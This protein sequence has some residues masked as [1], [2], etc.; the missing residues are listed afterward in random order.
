MLQEQEYVDRLVAEY[1]GRPGSLLT[2]LERVQERASGKYLSA[3]VLEYIA[4]KMNL[5]LSQVHSVVTFY[6]LFNLEPQGE[7]TIC[8]CRGTACHTRGSRALL[9][10]LKL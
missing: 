5:P 6:A 7:N 3:E 1:Q 4:A 2:I 8:V 10:R 9:E